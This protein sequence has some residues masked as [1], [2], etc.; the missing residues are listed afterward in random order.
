MAGK[1][2]KIHNKSDKPDN[3]VKK[4]AQIF[5][6]CEDIESELPK[7]LRGFF[8]YLKGNVLPM[9]RLA[10][11]HDIKF[12]CNYLIAETDLTKAET[13]SQITLKEFAE[14]KAADINIYLDYCRKYKVETEKKHL[15]L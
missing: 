12:F 14:I 7:F 2:I 11:L 10:Y 5:Q 1:E 6:E 8:I 15:R 3:I 9:S 13:T 4:E